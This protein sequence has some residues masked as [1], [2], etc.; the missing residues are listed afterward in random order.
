MVHAV[1]MAGGRGTRFWPLS[2]EDKPK[3]FLNLFGKRSLLQNTVDRIKE[4]IPIERNIVV[5][6]ADYTDLVKDQLPDLPDENIIGEPVGRNTAPCVAMAATLLKKRDPE[7]T[8]IVL[9]ADHFIKNPKKFVSILKTA[10]NQANKGE[11]LVT[12]GIKPSRPETGYGYIQYD[13]DSTE[14][15]GDHA[16]NIVKTFT[17]KPDQFT[18]EKFIDSGDFLWNSGMFIWKAS[19]ILNQ[20]EQHLPEVY[21]ETEALT[22]KLQTSEQD[23]AINTF[24]QNSISISIDYGVME[25]AST[26]YVVPGAFGWNDVGSWK[27]VY[28]LEDKDQNDNVNKAEVSQLLH[29]HDNYI[30]V[31]SKKLVALVGVDNL[32]IVETD[33]ALLICDMNNSQDVKKIVNELR[34]DESRKEYL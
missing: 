1:I 10:V 6:N 20:M 29:S 26:V 15:V 25:K 3:Q 34:E 14:Q 9:P 11:N 17:E 5:T 13:V 18:A 12:I 19:T 8:M 30:S 33:N 28:E 31:N 16:V 7:A 22:E 4:Y 32:A 27:A 24:Y 23:E 2:T 21:S